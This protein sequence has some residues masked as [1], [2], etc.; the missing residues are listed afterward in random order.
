[1]IHRNQPSDLQYPE[2][3]LSS[4]Y[5]MDY[6]CQESQ[7]QHRPAAIFNFYCAGPARVVLM[8]LNVPMLSIPVPLHIK[9]MAKELLPPHW[10]HPHHPRPAFINTR[11]SCGNFQQSHLLGGHLLLPLPLPGTPTGLLATLLSYTRGILYLLK[12]EAQTK[13]LT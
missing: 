2:I 3:R 6:P 5:R 9:N 12:G 10:Y 4:A 1:M 13:A 7:G 11:K 8:G